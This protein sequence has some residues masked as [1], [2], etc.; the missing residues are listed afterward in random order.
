MACIQL[1]DSG[2]PTEA[3]RAEYLRFPF[4]L[5]RTLLRTGGCARGYLDLGFALRT[6]HLT[7]KDCELV[8]LRVA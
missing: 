1:P 4:N 3:E 5:T 2:T 8:I 7:D 6:T